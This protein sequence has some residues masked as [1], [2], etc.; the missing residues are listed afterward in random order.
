MGVT[1]VLASGGPPPT[2]DLRAKHQRVL[3]LSVA[4]AFALVSMFSCRS[5]PGE[6]GPAP[7]P[8]GLGAFRDFVGDWYAHDSSLTIMPD[9]SGR[10]FWRSYR[11]CAREP[12]PCDDRS[13]GLRIGNSVVHFKLSGASGRS[14]VAIVQRSNDPFLRVGRKMPITRSEDYLAFGKFDGSGDVFD[15]DEWIFCSADA[16]VTPGPGA[17]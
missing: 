15:G 14:A 16:P 6:V 9:G 5:E 12:A 4:L 17:C 3:A 11:D 1:H 13:D 10:I 8:F 7:S 2:F